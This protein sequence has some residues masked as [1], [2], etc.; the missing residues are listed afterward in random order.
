MKKALIFLVIVF[1]PMTSLVSV[2]FDQI[3]MRAQAAEAK[4]KADR[5][6]LIA[7]AQAA[8]FAAGQAAIAGSGQ[9]GVQRSF[10]AWA[11]DLFNPNSPQVAK[12]LADA[13]NRFK[14]YAAYEGMKQAFCNASLQAN[15]TDWMV[16]EL[17][18]QPSEVLK[19]YQKICGDYNFIYLSVSALFDK[20]IS[21]YF[22][23]AIANFNYVFGY[24]YEK[25]QK[26]APNF[27]KNITKL[28]C[29]SSVSQKA[30][31][32]PKMPFDDTNKAWITGP[33][34]ISG[35]PNLKSYKELCCAQYSQLYDSTT[36]CDATK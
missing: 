3:K 22:A 16:E 18:K 6:A 27:T 33:L 24:N 29:D 23:L 11:S 21:Q 8:A 14:P 17:L 36:K 35:Y 30:I 7:R 32:L 13:V 4:A 5:E 2:S 1:V 19:D 28:F 25:K 20:R 9:A 15:R 10:E 12:S 26:E 31:E 34:K